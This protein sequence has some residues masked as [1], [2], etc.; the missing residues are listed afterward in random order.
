M[1]LSFSEM[2]IQIKEGFFF[3]L[4]LS[5]PK[6]SFLEE[7]INRNSTFIQMVRCV[8]SLC[9]LFL[10]FLGHLKHLCFVDRY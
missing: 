7:R 8:N 1:P 4:F 9:A 2:A 3:L 6:L 10:V 5:F